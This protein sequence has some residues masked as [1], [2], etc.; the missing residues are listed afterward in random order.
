M[1]FGVPL[2]TCAEAARCLG[3]PASTFRAWTRGGRPLVSGLPAEGRG[4]PCVPFAGLAEGMV[5][6]ALR[7]AGVPLRRVRPALELVRARI[8]VDHVLASREFSVRGA[9]LL[10]EAGARD[11]AVRRDGRYAFHPVIGRCLRRISYDERYACRLLLPAYEVA[12]IAVDPQINFGRPY[13]AHSGT[14]VFAVSGL[15]R[16]GETIEDVAD[17]Y[18][19]P[20]DQVTEVAQRLLRAVA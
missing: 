6:S 13:F 10:W 4:W 15:L 18:G 7:Q 16:A 17:D 14:P 9:R 2:Y 20:A 19:I 11:L 8:G 3:V 12:R 1:R 5:L